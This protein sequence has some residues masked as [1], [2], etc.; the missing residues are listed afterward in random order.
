MGII[1]A[2]HVESVMLGGA[3]S[4]V[5][6][7]QQLG[8]SHGIRRRGWS[9]SVAVTAAYQGVVELCRICYER[10]SRAAMAA[11]ACQGMMK[12]CGVRHKKRSGIVGGV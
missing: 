11:V 1:V 9:R 5:V 12:L 4:V 10:W 8:E 3:A 7:C 6:T 2:C